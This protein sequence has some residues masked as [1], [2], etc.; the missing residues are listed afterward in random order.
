[1]FP[2]RSAAPLQHAWIIENP[3]YR[4]LL[5]HPFQVA[6]SADTEDAGDVLII[7]DLENLVI[8]YISQ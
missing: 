8:G 6:A 5:G 2:V 4:L 7:V 3:P 1:M